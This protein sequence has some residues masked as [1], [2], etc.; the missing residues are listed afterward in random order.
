MAQ[1]QCGKA[2][3]FFAQLSAN[4]EFSGC[5]VIALIKEQIESPLDR[6]EM[7]GRRVEALADGHGLARGFERLARERRYRVGRDGEEL[8]ATVVAMA[9]PLPVPG[10]M[11]AGGA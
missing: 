4:C 2:H 11:G 8:L 5:A 1:K 9:R 7:L 10:L 6:G 3:R